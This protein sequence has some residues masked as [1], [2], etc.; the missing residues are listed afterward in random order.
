MNKKTLIEEISSKN[1]VS[2][3]KALEIVDVVVGAMSKALKKG[4]KVQLQGI[5]IFTKAKRS[6][7]VG[8]NPQTGETIQVP[9][10]NVVKFKSSSLLKKALN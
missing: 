8:R 4:E 7:R 9:A 2:K 1:E 3:A 5:G 6:A 10:Q